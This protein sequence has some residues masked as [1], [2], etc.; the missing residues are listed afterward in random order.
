MRKLAMGITALLYMAAQGS[1]A[2][3]II[4]A[5]DYAIDSDAV[6]ESAVREIKSAPRDTVDVVGDSVKFVTDEAV[7]TAKGVAAAFKSNPI[8]KVEKAGMLAVA[9]AWDSSNDIIFRSY[10]ISPAVG[11]ELLGNANVSEGDVVDVSG[12]FYGIDFPKKA[13]AFFR[14]EFNRLFIRNTLD[15]LFAI[16]D[17]LAE[18][19]SAERDLMGKQI[20]IETKFVE[21]NQST[22]Q[23]LGFNWRFDSKNGG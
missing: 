14:P 2:E 10:K 19:H 15:N 16:E 13:S 7:T 5:Q 4:V 22:L 3:T 1:M 23:E 9:N 21:V 6:L 8:E 11:E 17:V 12:A 18:L 20:A